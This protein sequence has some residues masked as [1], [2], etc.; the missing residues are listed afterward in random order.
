MNICLQPTYLIPS[1]DNAKVSSIEIH[2]LASVCAA[3]SRIHKLPTVV[4]DNMSVAHQC[5]G[6]E[7]LTVVFVRREIASYM[8]QISNVLFQVDYVSHVRH[9]RG[10]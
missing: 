7:D 8:A 9:A 2:F 5:I 1:V 10:F 4:N 6:K 3:D